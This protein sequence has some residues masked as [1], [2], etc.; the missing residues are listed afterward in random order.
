MWPLRDLHWQPRGRLLH[1]DGR[2]GGRPKRVWKQLEGAGRRLAV[3]AS[4]WRSDIFLPACPVFPP[5]HWKQLGSQSIRVA[6]SRAAHSRSRPVGSG[7]DV[8]SLVRVPHPPAFSNGPGKVRKGL[9]PR[10]SPARSGPPRKLTESPCA[11]RTGDS[12]VAKPVRPQEDPRLARHS[13]G[14]ESSMPPWGCLVTLP[15]QGAPVGGVEEWASNG[16]PWP[17]RGGV[18]HTCQWN[19]PAAAMVRSPVGASPSLRAACLCA[20]SGAGVLLWRG[21]VTVGQG[22]VW[23]CW[24]RAVLAGPDSTAAVAIPPFLARLLLPGGAPVA[25][26]P[27][28][29]FAPVRAQ[30]ACPVSSPQACPAANGCRSLAGPDRSG[31]HPGGIL[32]CRGPP[33]NPVSALQLAWSPE[34][35]GAAGAGKPG[36][37]R[38][39]LRRLPWLPAR[40]GPSSR[41]CWGLRSPARLGA[42]LLPEGLHPPTPSLEIGQR[43]GG[44]CECRLQQGLTG[45]WKAG[46][47]PR[48]RPQRGLGCC[49]ACAL[50]GWTASPAAFGV[51]WA[52][53]VP[54]SC[55]LPALFP[56]AP[57]LAPSRRPGVC[58]PHGLAGR[59][60]VEAACHWAPRDPLACAVHHGLPLALQVQCERGPA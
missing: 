45:W 5:W 8:S 38:G 48:R 37:A 33:R 4:R 31:P 6:T 23:E 1:P 3:S 26:S 39:L 60:K 32:P 24:R 7:R 12:V 41:G 42:R 47:L 57:V 30:P 49:S 58:G 11:A 17:G 36:S 13:T 19:C 53:W 21:F 54:L 52:L 2:G 16:L 22:W 56:P 46:L 9:C 34:A 18:V 10:T 29:A 43:G 35:G 15:H 14:A 40:L 55:P 25:P 50:R 28:L 51:V 27:A 20:R 59:L 44:S